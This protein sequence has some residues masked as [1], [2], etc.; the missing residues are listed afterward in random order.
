MVGFLRSRVVLERHFCSTLAAIQGG[1]LWIVNLSVG[2]VRQCWWKVADRSAIRP[3]GSRSEP[4]L[5][6]W[7]RRVRFGPAYAA[8][9]LL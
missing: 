5:Q 4:R 7:R 1:A 6:K 2:C 9:F 8:K 3:F